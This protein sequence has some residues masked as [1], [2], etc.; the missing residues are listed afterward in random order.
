MFTRSL[1]ACGLIVA[2][3]SAFAGPKGPGAAGYCDVIAEKNDAKKTMTVIAMVNMYDPGVEESN[4]MS[5]IGKVVDVKQNPDGSID[6]FTFQKVKGGKSGK[7][8][9]AVNKC[10]RDLL[11]VIYPALNA[12]PRYNKPVKIE[13]FI[14]EGLQLTLKNLYVK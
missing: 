9:V 3:L 1:V 12:L 5:M 7:V 14:S 10:S 4:T 2:S 8:N 13:V 6:S 11:N